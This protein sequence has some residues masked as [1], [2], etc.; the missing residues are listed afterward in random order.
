MLRIFVLVLALVALP[1]RAEEIVAGLSQEHVDIT[2]NFDGSDI[3]VYG[4]VKRD[5]P[6][7]TGAIDIII[8]I[9]GPSSPLTIR[10]K[11]KRFGIWVN[12]ESVELGAAPSFYAVATTG[13]LVDILSPEEDRMHRISVEQMIRS[14]GVEAP[15]EDIRDALIRIREN[16]DLYQELESTI[17]LTD[18]TLFRTDIALPANLTEGTYHTRMF[19]LRDQEVVAQTDTVIDVRKVG[20]ERF[21]YNLAHD[22]PLAYGLLSLFIAVAAGWGASTIFRYIK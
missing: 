5:A 3:L 9:S 12:T 20:L 22:L 18:D 15:R 10:R 13:P 2:T 21:L 6:L 4:A 19:I 1:L 8:A 11:D 17:A 14:D 16:G 7:P